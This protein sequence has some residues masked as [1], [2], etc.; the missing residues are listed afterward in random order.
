VTDTG[1]LMT[2]VAVSHFSLSP[3]ER[4]PLGK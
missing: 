2:N 1:S 3:L 4:E